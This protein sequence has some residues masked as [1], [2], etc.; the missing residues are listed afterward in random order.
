M[1]IKNPYIDS[2]KGGIQCKP[3]E[4]RLV[5]DKKVE[6]DEWSPDAIRKR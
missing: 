5:L 6:F 4:D 2:T 1:K 3:I